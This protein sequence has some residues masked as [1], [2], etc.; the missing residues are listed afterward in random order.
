MHTPTHMKDIGVQSTASRFWSCRPWGP[1]VGLLLTMR[2]TCVVCALPL[3]R[4][5]RPAGLHP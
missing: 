3:V 5:S 1:R 4:R 2:V